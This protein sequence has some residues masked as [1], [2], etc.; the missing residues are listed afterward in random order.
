MVRKSA[1]IL[2]A[3]AL[4]VATMAFAQTDSALS[5]NVKT[6][7]AA[8]DMVKGSSVKVATDDHVVTLSGTVP[9]KRPG[10][11]RSR[12]RATRRA[13]LRSSTS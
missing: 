10:I 11:A 1:L 4:S 5:A 3:L 9:S 6:K 2:C 8:D 7:L 13:S 12:S